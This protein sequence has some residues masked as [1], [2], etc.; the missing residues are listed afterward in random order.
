MPISYACPHCGNQTQVSDE[1]AGMSG[2]CAKCGQTITIP[3]LPGQAALPPGYAPPARK[4]SPLKWVLVIVGSVLLLLCCSGI[5][6]AL[7]LPAVHATREAARRTT[8]TNNLKQ[9][10][11]ALHN[12]HASFGSFPPAY[13]PDADGRPLVSWRVLILPFL[14]EQ[15]LYDEYKLDEPW[16]SP[17]NLAL[18]HR[19]PPY[20]ACPS[21]PDAMGQYTSYVANAGPNRM[22]QAPEPIQLRDITDGMS[23]TIAVME[24]ADSKIVWTEPR[25]TSDQIEY[26]SDPTNG[27]THPGG[28]NALYADGSVQFLSND[29]DTA[30]LDQLLIINDEGAAGA[31]RAEMDNDREPGAAYDD[32]DP[33]STDA[34]P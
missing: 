34:E 12:Y 31:P 19:M 28:S 25:D 20:F 13:I 27:S 22:F 26:A 17:H 33:S 6:I 29:M 23:N 15:E 9:I 8:C 16:D 18:A 7:L 1:F 30:V 5:P 24:A 11:L 3:G 10:G 2:P 14:E 4:S 32:R 21:D